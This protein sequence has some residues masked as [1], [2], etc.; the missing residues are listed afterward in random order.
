MIGPFAQVERVRSSMQ[1]TFNG[2]VALCF[3]LA[4]CSSA[5]TT[6]LVPGS[7]PLA[8]RKFPSVRANGQKVLFV[9]DL[10]A[11]AVLKYP[12]NVNHPA[13]LGSITSGVSRPQGVAVDAQG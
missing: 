7:A 4:A 6:R 12:A 3:L 1:R 5:A 11:N 2:A 8:V 9:A 13:S 10:G